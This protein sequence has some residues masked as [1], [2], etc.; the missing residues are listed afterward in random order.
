[1]QFSVDNGQCKAKVHCFMIVCNN[2]RIQCEFVMKRTARSNFLFYSVRVNFML[3]RIKCA[4]VG[5]KR[6]VNCLKANDDAIDFNKQC[7]A[8]Q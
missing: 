7:Y 5:Y 1:M 3:F 4:R 2:A 8:L 6:V